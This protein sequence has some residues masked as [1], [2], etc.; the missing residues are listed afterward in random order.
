MFVHRKSHIIDV[1]EAFEIFYACCSSSGFLHRKFMAKSRALPHRKVRIIW[2]W[3]KPSLVDDW[4]TFH[5]FGR[6]LNYHRRL[7]VVKLHVLLVKVSS[8]VSKTS[9]KAVT[10]S[11]LACYSQT[12]KMC[13]SIRV[14]KFHSRVLSSIPPPSP[15]V[16]P[17]HFH[18]I[19]QKIL[20]LCKEMIFTSGIPNEDCVGGNN[21]KMLP[22]ITSNHLYQREIVK[23]IFFNK[24]NFKNDEN[25]NVTT[26]IWDLGVCLSL[27]AVSAV[28]SRFK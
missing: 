22:Q 25:Y 7:V 15:P 8:P 10:F 4:K 16:S 24:Y 3:A 26:S 2:P 11:R 20:Q 13:T 28:I 19:V 18:M 27:Y 12:W 17:A 5:Q 1:V 23:K 21:E 9:I 6:R 14:G